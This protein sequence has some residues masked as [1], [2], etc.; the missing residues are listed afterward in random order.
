MTNALGLLGGS[1]RAIHPDWSW[2]DQFLESSKEG[3]LY[4]L[5]L[6]KKKKT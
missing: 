4:L 5:L 3:W 1:D 6:K 2:E